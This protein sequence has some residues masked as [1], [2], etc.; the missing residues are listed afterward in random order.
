ML[1]SKGGHMDVV[2]ELLRAHAAV[3]VQDEVCGFSSDT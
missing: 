2:K 3:N 1:A